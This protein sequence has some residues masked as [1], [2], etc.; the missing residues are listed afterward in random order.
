M[1]HNIRTHLAGSSGLRPP[2]PAGNPKPLNILASFTDGEEAQIRVKA[3][4]DA[5]VTIFNVEEN[6]RVSQIFPRP[7]APQHL[8]PTGQEMIFPSDMEREMGIHLR[9]RTP[10]KHSSALE[11]NLVIATKKNIQFFDGKPN[12]PDGEPPM[13]TDLMAELAEIVNLSTWDHAVV[14]YKISK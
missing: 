7:R 12:G 3:N 9:V 14:G 4:E 5:F 2:P 6:G 8:L 11:S 1:P 10:P 13:L